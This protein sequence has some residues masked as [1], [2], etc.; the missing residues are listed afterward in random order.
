MTFSKDID[1]VREWDC[2]SVTLKHV[3]GNGGYFLSC[4]DEHRFYLFYIYVEVCFVPSNL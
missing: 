3:C 4:S 2:D 1:R